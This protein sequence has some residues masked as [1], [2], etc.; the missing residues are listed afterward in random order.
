[1]TKR[2]NRPRGPQV[3]AGAVD[4]FLQHV[5]IPYLDGPGT[6]S[7]EAWF[8]GS[9]AENAE[10]F[11]RLIVEAIR[12]QAFWRR[13][14][15]PGDPTLVTEAVK[16]QPEY[17]QAMGAL[18]DSYRSLLG[19]LKRSMPF[20]ST[21]Y[22]GHMNWDTAMPA[23]LGYFAAMLYNPNNVAFEASTATTI[24]ELLV[25]DD[26][27]R[28]IGYP[29]PDKAA[30][31]AGAVRPWGHITSGGTVAN[32][33]AL[34]SAR[35]LKL[36]PVAMQAAL[37]EDPTL[38]A[39]SELRVRSPGGALVLLRELD[40]WS[41]CNLRGDDILALPA[42]LTAEYGIAPD[43]ITA[44][45]AKVSP[46]SIG[47]HAFFGRYLGELR[48]PPV[49][50]VPATKHYSF[51]KAA[52][53][54]GL[55]AA[56][57]LDVPLDE[58]ARMSIPELERILLGCLA[59]RRP[60]Y[61]VVG[62]I[63]STEESA[64]DPLREILA[65]R[66]KLRD[67]GLE[68]TVH[69]DAAWGGYH[70]SILREDDDAPA[71]KR[72]APASPRAEV[73]FS[74][75]TEE[76]YAVLHQADSVTVDPHKSGYIPYPA[77]ALC[78]RNTAMRD[79]VTFKA[80]YI[81]HAQDE[82]S[83]GIYGVEGSKPGAAVAAVFLAHKVIR[84]SRSGY[85]SIHRKA[86]FNCR[87]VYARLLCMARP[88]DNFVVVP[89]PRLPAEIAGGDVAAQIEFIRERIDGRDPDA[90][91]ADEEAMA[92]LAEIGPDLNI[93]TYAFNF[94]RPDG[95]MNTS[96]AQANRLNKAVYEVLSLRPGEDPSGHPLLVTTT[97][98]EDAHY[99]KVFMDSYKRRLGVDGPGHAVTVLRST[100]MNPWLTDFGDDT[101]LDMLEREFRRALSR[102]MFRDSMA[103]VFEEIDA[104]NDGS[105]DRAEVEA[106]FRAM[107]YSDEEIHEFLRS[108]DTSRD[109][110]ISKQEFLE[111]FSQLL[112]RTSLGPRR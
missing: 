60:V 15:H 28:M 98:F 99:G 62:V 8:L 51:P 21:R 49:V 45:L 94:K 61:T 109:N 104:N 30:C 18:T 47:M 111:S 107:G 34:W 96:L 69:A 5:E 16:R 77:G 22:Q 97:D 40:A 74:R 31:Q 82:P 25:G 72:T 108:S 14:F 41:L 35:N 103:Q 29:L 44:A 54:L 79:L 38:A 13:N 112:V 86:L 19:F 3:S 32:I 46:Q 58:N 78:Y 70:A 42:R 23:V 55:G 6:S 84:P 39:A 50:L 89:V 93:L 105:L 37:K 10:E 57:V 101:F 66:D 27:C 85:G 20:F 52:A 63:G 1:M 102:A 75:Y 95:A 53:I 48:N 9:K 67:Q 7:P 90:L 59:E 26:L 76:Q 12:D 65:L 4:Q 92:L 64:V 110:N 87:R 33:E 11:E 2:P 83:V 17:V 81:L 71:G 56:N 68:F 73:G 36:Y 43:V 91:L 88:E 24:L 100:V 106:K 80:P